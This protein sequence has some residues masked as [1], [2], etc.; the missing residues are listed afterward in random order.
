MPNDYTQHFLNKTEDTT[1]I[2]KQN[3]EFSIRLWN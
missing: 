3:I 1:E 2:D